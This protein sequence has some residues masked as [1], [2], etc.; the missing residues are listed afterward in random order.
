MSLATLRGALLRIRDDFGEVWGGSVG[1]DL[2]LACTYCGETGDDYRT[3]VHDEDCA[4]AI[5]ARALAAD[6]T[7]PPPFDDAGLVEAVADDAFRHPGYVEWEKCA[8]SVR[9]KRR[10]VVRLVLRALAAYQ[11]GGR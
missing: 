8:E 7:E 10:D 6:S 3:I 4:V 1:R 11:A 2:K 9:E 5:A